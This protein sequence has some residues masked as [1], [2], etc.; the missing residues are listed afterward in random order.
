MCFPSRRIAYWKEVETIDDSDPMFA[1]AGSP[2]H[3]SVLIFM[4]VMDGEAVQNTMPKKTKESI[5]KFLDAFS[6]IG[7]VVI[8]YVWR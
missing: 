4:P 8:P 6:P 2:P 1:E 3:A 5:Q 7:R